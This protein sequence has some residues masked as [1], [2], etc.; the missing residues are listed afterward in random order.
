MRC[1]PRLASSLHTGLPMLGLAALVVAAPVAI[2]QSPY[3][4]RPVVVVAPIAPGGP[5]DLEARLHTR[6]MTELLGQSFVLDFKPGA[7]GSIGN[8]YVA[9]AAPDGYTLLVQSAGF[10]V[11]PFLYKTLTY[12]VM[13]DFA[14]VSMISQRMSVFLVRNGFPAKSF[15]EYLAYAKANP[16]KVNYG[17]TGAGGVGHL[18]GAWIEKETGTR[19]T[20]VH[21]KG[22]APQ[23]V[24]LVAERLDVVSTNLITGLPM[25]RTGKARGLAV[26]SAQR[27]P[28]LPNL[29]TVAE[30]G[31]PG[32][33]YSSWLGFLAPAGTP[34][35]IVNQLGEGFARVAK[36]PDIVEALEKDGIT[37]VG[38]T[39]AQ[40]RQTIAADTERWGRL[41]KETGVK[42]ED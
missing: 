3:P 34:A 25:M 32:Y 23:L 4:T 27:S 16:G 12:D 24:D 33:N 2:A 21:Y 26:M 15:T 37:P 36:S 41:V 30:Q 7:G 11:T 1:S 14:P 39:P 22:A 18:A 31:I 5:I 28:L 17:T 29:P 38:S 35:A 13:R 42:L 10:T 6:K 8:G 19:V 9:K 20:Y 40:F